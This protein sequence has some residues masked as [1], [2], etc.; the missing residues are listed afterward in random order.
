[1]EWQV[2]EILRRGNG[3]SLRISWDHFFVAF[4]VCLA[5]GV[6]VTMRPA[7]IGVKPILCRPETRS[8]LNQTTYFLGIICLLFAGLN[9]LAEWKGARSGVLATKIAASSCFLA[10]GLLNV[11]TSTYGYVVAAALALSWIGDVMLV[12]RTN[13]A[14]LGGIG[15]FLFAHIAYAIAFATQP[16]DAFRFGIAFLIWNV[17]VVFLLRWLWNY[18]AGANRVAVLIYM[19]AITVMV[20]LAAAT[21]S[22]LIGVAAGLFAI[23]DISVARDRFVERSVAN[24]VWGIPLYYLAQV[25]LAFSPAFVGK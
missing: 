18:L 22:P 11:G 14:L 10:I 19:A 8:N 15:A 1:M 17:V 7:I 6:P 5:H 20:S 3:V 16:L 4:G 21:L 13:A 23:S 9:V 2:N 25:M 12:W 24:K